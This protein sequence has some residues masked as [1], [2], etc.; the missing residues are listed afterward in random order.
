M[1]KIKLT[2]EQIKNLIFNEIT[3]YHGSNADF[4]DFDLGFVNTGNKMQA[5]GYGIYVALNKDA[6]E[7][8]GD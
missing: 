1:A 8:Y 5:Y 4:N 3:A 2:E 6:A 7:R